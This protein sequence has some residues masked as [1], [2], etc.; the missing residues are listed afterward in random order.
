MFNL[1]LGDMRI[2]LSSKLLSIREQ[3]RLSQTEMAELLSLSTS[4][5]QRLERGETSCDMQ[6][7][8]KFSEVLQVPI[9]DLLP[10]T[11]T[12]NNHNEGKGPG[13]IFGN[14]IVNIYNDTDI[15]NEIQDLKKI[16]QLLTSNFKKDE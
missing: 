13:V 10:D 2:K 9:Q 3:R 1:I 11:V 8:V 7:L 12:L 5:Y 6:Q 16:I 15:K 4:A 14:Y